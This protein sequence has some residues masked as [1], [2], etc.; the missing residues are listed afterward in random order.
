M[1]STDNKEIMFN[2]NNKFDMKNKSSITR[3]AKYF[4]YTLL[5]TVIFTS[6][7]YGVAKES[8][9]TKALEQAYFEGQR[10]ALENDVRIKRNQDSC[11]IWIKSPWNSGKQP[12]FNPSFDCR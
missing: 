10:D 6:C 9:L 8:D 3:K 1:K 7:D 5:A 4:L 2:Y 12:I 11:W